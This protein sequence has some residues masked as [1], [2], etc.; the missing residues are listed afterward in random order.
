[1]TPCLSETAQR[2]LFLRSGLT[3]DLRALRSLGQWFG[4]AARA[5]PNIGSSGCLLRRRLRR[6]FVRLQVKTVTPLVNEFP[7]G[8]RFLLPSRALLALRRPPG[9]G[10]R[11]LLDRIRHHFIP[12]TQTPFYLPTEFCW[13]VAPPCHCESLFSRWNRRCIT[14]V[15]RELVGER[16]ASRRLGRKKGRHPIAGACTR[17]IGW[18]TFGKRKDDAFPFDA[19]P[20]VRVRLRGWARPRAQGAQYPKNTVQSKERSGVRSTWQAHTQNRP[21]SE[22]RRAVV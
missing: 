19:V 1:M 4:P 18:R 6:T 16:R 5:N 3:A 15:L 2:S 21:L 7:A 9:C 17:T 8:H 22:G 20:N 13:C 12:Y 11:G 10:P 14:S